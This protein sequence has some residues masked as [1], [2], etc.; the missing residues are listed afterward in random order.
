MGGVESLIMMKR[1]DVYDIM[2]CEGK[3]ATHYLHK[4]VPVD[5]GATTTGVHNML[6]GLEFSHFTDTS[7]LSI[8][9]TFLSPASLLTDVPSADHTLIL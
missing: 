1:H 2:D 4:T 9:A 7:P 3:I 8:V 5:Q 6:L